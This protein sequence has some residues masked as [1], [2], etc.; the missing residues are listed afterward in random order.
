MP[1]R[2][3]NTDRAQGETAFLSRAVLSKEMNT[4]ASLA[5]VFPLTPDKTEEWRDWGEEIRGPRFRSGI[6]RHSK[7]GSDENDQ[8]L[9]LLGSSLTISS[10]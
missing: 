2:E 7:G 8:F 9:L 6:A 4:M 3:S 10:T 1:R 5:F